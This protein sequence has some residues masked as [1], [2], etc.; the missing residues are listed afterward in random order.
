MVGAPAGIQL[1]PLFQLKS[2]AYPTQI[3][4]V[5][6]AA[7]ADPARTEARVRVLSAV[8]FRVN[9]GCSF[10]SMSGVGWRPGALR[11]RTSGRAETSGGRTGKWEEDPPRNR[12]MLISL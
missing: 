4:S 3:L 2:P 11:T 9:M 8:R 6:S 12:T 1:A 7:P 10:L 5:A